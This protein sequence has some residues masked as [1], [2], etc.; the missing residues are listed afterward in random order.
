MTTGIYTLRK[1]QRA[2]FYRKMNPNNAS[3]ISELTELGIEYVTLS[4]TGI[5]FHVGKATSYIKNPSER[6]NAPQT[7]V[8]I[9]AET[10]FD[11][12]DAKGRLEAYTGIK[13][14]KVRK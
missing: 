11:E 10:D 2:E 1:A 5:V 6:T 9:V 7:L 8:R 13:L 14:I 12:I 3:Q 4:P